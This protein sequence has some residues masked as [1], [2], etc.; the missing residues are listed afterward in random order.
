[1]AILC[2]KSW[3]IVAGFLYIF[4]MLPLCIAVCVTALLC[5]D[6]Y[7]QHHN[8]FAITPCCCH[9]CSVAAGLLLLLYKS[10]CSCSGYLRKCWCWPNL[11][12]VTMP[13]VDNLRKIHFSCRSW[14][15]LLWATRSHLDSQW[16]CPCPHVAACP[17]VDCCY[18]INEN[19]LLPIAAMLQHHCYFGRLIVAFLFRKI[20]VA[21]SFTSCC[22]TAAV[23]KVAA[24]ACNAIVTTTASHVLLAL[25]ASC[26][27]FVGSW[28]LL[29]GTS[30]FSSFFCWF[31]VAF[32][33]CRFD[34]SAN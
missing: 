1:M 15:H 33:C 29:Y 20:A 2:A 24:P 7:C 34:E 17:T 16:C 3:L 21:F 11:L 19:I 6:S 12:N 27:T 18:W 30:L 26:F 28:L 9:H 14:H 32:L 23:A 31:I 8:V 5:S 10:W 4:I 22:T 13:L 25:A